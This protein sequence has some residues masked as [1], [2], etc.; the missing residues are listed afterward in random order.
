MSIHVE[1]A[2]DGGVGWGDSAVVVPLTRA[3]GSVMPHFKSRDKNSTNVRWPN[4]A[5]HT[6]STVLITSISGRLMISER[7]VEVLRHSDVFVPVR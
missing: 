3:G 7:T 2:R 6:Q 5:H 4:T 1:N